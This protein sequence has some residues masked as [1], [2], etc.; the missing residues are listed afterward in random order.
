M[1][2]G[3]LLLQTLTAQNITFSYTGF[4][5]QLPTLLLVLAGTLLAGAVA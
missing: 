3:L 1:T 4:V 5:L 2:A